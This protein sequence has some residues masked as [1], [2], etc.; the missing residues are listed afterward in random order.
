MI[1][2]P[3]GRRFYSI[4]FK[5]Q[6]RP[7][8]KRTK[9]TSAKDARAIEA[10][11]RSELARGNFGILQPKRA[12]TLAEFLRKDFGPFSEMR[13][14]AKP[15]TRDYYHYGMERLLASDIARLHLDQITSQH[16]TCFAGSYSHLS[17]STI[18]CSLRTLRRALNLAEKWG[19][20]AKAPDIELAKGERQ[21]DRVVTDA[22]FA[23]YIELCRQPWHD[24]ALLIRHEGMCPGECY[25]LE[26]KHILLNG[27]GGLI[28]IADGKTKARRRVLPMQPTV[29]Q[30]LFARWRAQGE[31]AQGWVFPSGS[32]SGH[33]DENSAKNQHL[34]A[35]HVIALAHKA[36]QE[37]ESPEWIARNA[38]G[39]GADFVRRHAATIK[40]GVKPFEPYC[41]RHTAL[42]RLAEAGCDAFT[43]AKIAGHSSIIMT[44]RY[45]HPQ[46]EAIERAFAKIV[47]QATQ[48]LSYSSS[49][50][51]DKECSC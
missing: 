28:Q 47:A 21:R 27:N 37:R 31:P 7:I 32:A 20:L 2:K 43:L 11:M 16:A 15:K 36:R 30:A 4:K 35:L 40:A 38:G 22:E 46:A 18:N 50:T 45:C 26:W 12:P 5:T 41:L 44:Q 25:K 6:G 34:A 17:P 14:V 42:T 13:F 51:T 29:Y 10:T 1:H 49:V 24:V 3:E 48:S 33:F 19:K 9:A 39:P 23:I 8:Q